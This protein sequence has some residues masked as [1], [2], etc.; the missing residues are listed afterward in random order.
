[1][2]DD[3]PE[4][5]FVDPGSPSAKNVVLVL[6]VLLSD[7]RKFPKALS[8][9]NW[10]YLCFAHVVRPEALCVLSVLSVCVRVSPLEVENCTNI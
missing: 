3:C 7:F 4:Y 10:S 8:V 1:M 9:R 2:F 6:A 5:L